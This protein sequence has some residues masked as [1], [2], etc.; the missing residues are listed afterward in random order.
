MS[1]KFAN[2]TDAAM[3]NTTRPSAAGPMATPSIKQ[4]PQM[5][6]KMLPA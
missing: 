3:V 1:Q 5:A 4:A 2:I 6:W